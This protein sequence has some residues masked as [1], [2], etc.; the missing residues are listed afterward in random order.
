LTNA[1]AYGTAI[2]FL[3]E[4]TMLEKL[5][6]MIALAREQ[7]FGRAA[8]SCGVAQP[9]LSLGIQSL[10][11]MLN[12][13][14]VKRSSRFQGF[15][16]EGERVLVWARRLVGDAKAMRQD[17]LG[18]K[19]GVA[20][21]LRLAAIPS[22]MSLVAMLTVPFQSRHPNVRLT[23]LGR[24]SNTLLQLLHHR[25]IDVG[26]TY[27]TNEPI[28][29]VVSVPLYREQF[30]FL[31]T[32]E[33]P[34]GYADQVTWDEA[35]GV[36]LCLFGRDLQNRRIMD[37]ILR[38]AGAEPTP[39]METDSV[40]AL[41]AY[42]RLGATASIMP[43]SAMESVDLNHTMRAI[44]MVGP[45]VTHTIG[46]IVSERFPIQPAVDA[47]LDEARGFSSQGLLPAA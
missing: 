19:T 17:I 3:H 42:V 18:F 45:E 38:Q 13:A 10:E 36:P 28:G 5:E 43:T 7:H 33:G 34:L 47:L 31:T 41:L 11:Q 22:A 26:I 21:H 20:S 29:D 6:F 16:P 39:I 2:A 8:E 40:A 15:T 27:L 46:L 23:V 14:L 35:A 32:P 4:A 37:S 30:L 12:V 9:T 25:D 24:S 1:I 44:P